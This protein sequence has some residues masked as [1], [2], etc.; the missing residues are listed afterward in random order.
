MKSVVPWWREDIDNESR[1]HVI[2]RRGMCS[3]LSCLVFVH[4]L[5]V[6]ACLPSSSTDHSFFMLSRSYDQRH[7]VLGCFV[8]TSVRRFLT[9]A[10][11]VWSVQRVVLYIADTMLIFNMYRQSTSSL[12]ST[13][14]TI[15]NNLWSFCWTKNSLN[16]VCS[17][18]TSSGN[19][20]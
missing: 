1:N 7:V 3:S 12:Y 11:N 4:W 9:V 19:T 13:V 8:C 6:F 20:G 14:I 18:P 15:L 17:L 5:L 16:I 2:S 10:C